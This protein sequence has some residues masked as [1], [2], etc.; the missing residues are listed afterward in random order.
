MGKGSTFWAIVLIGLGCLLLLNNLGFFDVLRVN[1]WSLIWPLLLIALGVRLIARV[2][3]NPGPAEV[4]H[5]TIPLDG[6]ARAAIELS[7]GA[8]NLNVAAGTG[9]TGLVEG[10]FGGGLRQAV[11]RR[12]DLLNVELKMRV[13]PVTVLNWSPGGYDWN[14]RLNPDVPLQL[15]CE[16]GASRS[17]LDLYGLKVTELKLETNAST[18]DVVLPANAGFT[19]VSIEAGAARVDVRV[20][21]GVA[22]RIRTSAGLASIAVDTARFPGGDKLYQSPDYATAANKVDI[23]VETGLGTVAIS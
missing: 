18:T 23:E 17:T 3:G 11:T 4:E 16:T 2:V 21:G 12:D 7:H 5:A 1:L 22:A 10:E 8:G 9:M 20:P 19:Q 6:A 15:E 13:E 14:V